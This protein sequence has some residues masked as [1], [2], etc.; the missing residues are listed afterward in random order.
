MKKNLLLLFSV[1]SL[2]VVHAQQVDLAKQFK[3]LKPRNIGPAGM[4]GRVTAIDAVWTNPNIIYLGTASGGVWKTE[5][6]GGSWKS[7]FDEQPILNIGALAIT[8]SN[9]NIIWAGTGE[10]NPR[11]SVSLGEG[12]YKSIDGGKTW[13]CVGLQKT[14]NIHRIIID[15]NNP[16]VVYAGVMGNPFAEHAERGV[17]KTTDGGE[18]W[19]LILHTNDTSGV[20]DMV[21]DPS[22][23]NK[24]FVNMYQHKRTPWSLKG[25]GSGSGFY[26]TYDGGK[27][28]KKLGKEDG[29][30]DGEYGRI[31]ISISRTDPNKVYALVEA[32]KNGLYRSEDGGVK[33]ELVNSDPAVVTNRAFYFQDIAV[34]TK[35]ENRLYNINQMVNVSED[36]GKTFK[37]VL[38][39]S[40]IHPDHHA[41]WIHPYDANFIIDG[42]DGGIGISRDR[43]KTWQFDEKLPLGQFYHI[44]VDNQIPYNVMGGLQDNGSW[45]GP[46]YVWIQSGIRNAYWQGVN[47]GDGFDVVP[48]PE[49]P[50]WVYSMS[51]GGAVNRYNMATGEEWSIRP[52]RPDMKTRQRFNWN[53]AIALDPFDKSTVYY[54]S[55]FVNK[56]TN[57]GAS[58]EVISPDLTTNDSAKIDQSKNGGISVDITGAENHCTILAIEPSPKERGVI[59]VGTDDGNVQLTRDGGK[60]WTNFRGKIPGL[61]LGAWIPQI[62]A[63][64]HNAGEAFVVVNDYRRGDGKPYLFRTTDYGKT[65]SRL[66]DEK[67]VT[68]Y[69]LC[70][71]QDPAEPNLIFVGTEQGLW[72]SVDNG[73]SFQQFKNEYPSVSTYDLAIQER[74]ADLVIATFGR[75]LWILDDIRPLRKLASNKG[76]LFTQKLTAFE[77]PIA[78]QAKTKNAMGIEYSTYGTYEGENRKR[79]AALSFYV[80]KTSADTGKNKLADSVQVKI[81]DNNNVQVRSLKI[82]ADT[83][84]NRFYW[85]MEGKGIRQPGGGGRGRRGMGGN[86]NAEPGGLPVDPGT[87]KVVMSADKMGADSM[88]VLVNDDPKAPTSKEVRDAIKK[89]NTRLDQSALK[90]VELTDRITEAEEAI[91]KVEADLADMDKKGA[92]TLRKVSKQMTDSIKAIKEQLN[93]KAQE[94]QGY[95]NI[96]QVTVNSLLGDARMYILSKPVVP[97]AQEERLMADAEV[98]VAN[99]LKNANAFFNNSW[100]QYRALVEATPVKLFKEYKTI[101]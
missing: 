71:I 23:P 62:R 19:K 73:T 39:Y 66:V 52:P 49:D 29:L 83:G 47:G 28:F 93:G 6:G 60:T 68:G 15:P 4:S 100:K 40:G 54:G 18:T 69:A 2:F 7:I 94:K 14:R 85:G 89:A 53:A 41:W 13:K 61:P 24:L 32:T 86:S 12:M 42:N 101:E 8:Q 84:F 90:L 74:E 11:N 55:Q 98:A 67:K 10:G 48:D 79:G 27:T 82:K 5:N 50:N 26:V 58:W 33:W 65:W 36:G 16:E 78:Y 34:D 20:G 59:W 64:K 45:H 43:G 88:M 81:Y 57:K 80:N 25:G 30:P 17:Y 51:Q 77:A 46:A 3:N 1:M 87:Y 99:V 70:V 92:D 38:P 76:Q 37:S 31:G 22:N 21:M 72:V 91:K 75:A 9:P 95:G 63:S 44:N 97:G 96:P 35:N 56:S